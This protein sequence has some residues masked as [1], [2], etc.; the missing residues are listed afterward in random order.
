ML[1]GKAGILFGVLCPFCFQCCASS[2]LGA[3]FLTF[4]TLVGKIP[5]KQLTKGRLRCG[6]WWGWG[7]GIVFLVGV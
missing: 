2:V 7:A 5:N 6:S 4:L 3:I 1:A